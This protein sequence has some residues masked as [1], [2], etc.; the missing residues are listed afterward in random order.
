MNEITAKIQELKNEYGQSAEQIIASGLGM[1]KKGTKYKCPNGF[2]HR[3][4]D[5]DP[6]M[7]WDK[8]ALQ[9]YCFGCNHKIDIYSYF[10]DH[11]NYTAEEI[12]GDIKQIESS[13]SS[14]YSETKKVE[15]I[16]QQCIDYIK[17]REIT[18]QTI[19][20][21]NLGTYKNQIAFPYY[22]Y[23][24]VV[25]YKLRQPLVNPTGA[26]MTNIKGSKPYLFG[27]QNVENS[28]ELIVCEGEFDAMVIYQ[29][30]F[31]NVVSIGAGA[32]A[33]KTIFEQGK[34][35]LSKFKNIIIVSDNDEAGTKMDKDSLDFLGKKAKLI[36]KKLYASKDINEEYYKYGKDKVR[37]IIESARF[38][39][40]GRRDVDL[41]PYIGIFEN[42][43]R[44][45]PTGI[46]SVDNA[47]ND[48]EPKRVTL[49]TG[50]SNGGKTTFIKQII[51][52]AIDKKNKVYLMNGENDAD[53]LLNEL[54][55]TVIGNNK[56]YY[57]TRKI[58]KRYFKEPT[59]D[60]LV[61]LQNW[62]KNKL[63]M[64]NKGE[65]KL[66]TLD[67]LTKML[68]IEIKYNQYDL[69]V[70]DNLM[71]IL[72]VS[73]AEKYEQ[74]ADFTQRLC[75]LSK[76]YST[77]IIL[78]LHPNKTYQK[79]ADMDMEQISGSSDIYNKADNI[80]AVTREYDKDKVLNGINGYIQ[81]IK[82]RY[83]GE[84][85]K[86]ETSYDK[87]TGLLLEKQDNEILAYNFKFKDYYNEVRGILSG[88]QMAIN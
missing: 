58:N 30:G 61:A 1:E 87:N 64:F 8:K 83:Y 47:L 69:V 44:Y 49:V 35:F 72:S 52:N 18:E 84:L 82:N 51:A 2:A 41:V 68:E 21:F 20:D 24:T 39:I 53:M 59:L 38:K 46:P 57:D 32:N 48:L 16:N 5:R 11:L 65:S 34:E 4:N 71:S 22:K 81:V 37:K 70:I 76:L 79:G 60:S 66:K 15:E 36:D 73:S 80:I 3:N 40:E 25:G 56:E 14:F 77:H 27:C 42:N 54:Y 23:D 43:G 67:Q 74:Q 85:V 26:K 7:S 63:Y 13:R 31:K 29:C 75:D 55:K 45:V 33:I 62:H 19:K 78:V 86:V 10:K 6:S 17:T 88:E 9:F 28:N 50:R 12:L